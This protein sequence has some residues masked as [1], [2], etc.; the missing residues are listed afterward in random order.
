[1]NETHN[2]IPCEIE[3]PEG[4]FE[5]KAFIRS[6]RPVGRRS[7]YPTGVDLDELFQN[8]EML[9][10]SRVWRDV[11]GNLAAYAFVHFPYNNLTF[12]IADLYWSENLEHEILV[13]AEERMRQRYPTGLAAETLDGSCRAE[14]DR[15]KR[16]F[17]NHGFIK[18]QVE[19]ITYRVDL[20]NSLP[21]PVLPPGYSLRPLNPSSE[22]EKVV[23]LH[24]A[25]YGTR[26]F[27]IE[28][29]IAIMNTDA[30]LPE[31]DLVVQA[32]DGSLA[33]NCIC[34][35][36]PRVSEIEEER[37]YTDPVIVHPQHQRRG[38]AR[39]LLLEGLARLRERGIRFAELGTTNLNMGMRKAAEAAGF[40]C[41]SQ[42]VWYSK[43]IE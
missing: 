6:V 2:L 37:G 42:R 5:L 33:G 13:W 34:G 23:A 8:S 29:R 18:Q 39:A 17:V 10:N 11:E 19:S 4:L 1:M 31:A 7:D 25:A 28:E 14:D 15:M 43:K 35:I 22:I 38:I 27:S 9:Q 36:E 26:L 41:V 32:P 3:L 16:F 21:M 30:Y 24:Q 12:E 40:Q 20:M